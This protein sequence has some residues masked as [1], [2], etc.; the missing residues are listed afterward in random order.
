MAD[1]DA[2]PGPGTESELGRDLQAE[3]DGVIDDVLDVLQAAELEGVEL[4]PLSTIARRLKARGSELELESMPP[5]LRM[6]VAGMIDE[7]A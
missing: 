4:D 2:A 3:L 6:L 5:V 1:G 7:G